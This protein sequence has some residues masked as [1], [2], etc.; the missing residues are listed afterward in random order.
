MQAKMTLTG[1]QSDH[2]ITGISSDRAI[3]D[4][5][6]ETLRE[7][8]Q[9]GSSA[10]QLLTPGEDAIERSLEPESSGIWKTLIRSH[11]WLAVLGAFIGALIFLL[12]LQLEA[13]FVVDNAVAA[14]A[15]LIAF[16]T[17]GGLLLGGALTLR[18][19]H[20]PYLAAARAALRKG[21]TV[22]V[23]HAESLEQAQLAREILDQAGLRTVRTL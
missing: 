3:A 23:V 21:Q 17:I 12:M 6:I 1:E 19:D 10:V 13:R 9:L 2:K 22:V 5:A 7:R 20:M 18:P 14:G 15:L 8:L 11:L 16:C 4:T